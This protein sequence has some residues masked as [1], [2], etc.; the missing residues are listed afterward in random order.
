MN[1]SVCFRPNVN[2]DPCPDCSQLT[3]AEQK[4][5]H[6]SLKPAMDTLAMF[7]MAFTRIFE[8]GKGGSYVGK[9]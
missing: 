6:D 5:V 4:L 3:E 9:N 8:A 7:E 2:T 1:C